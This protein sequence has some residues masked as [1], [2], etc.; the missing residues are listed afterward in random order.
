MAA[1]TSIASQLQAIK[2]FVKADAEPLKKPFIRPSLLFD[3]KEAAD[4]DIDTIYS[5]AVSGLESLVSV[6]AHFEAYKNDLFSHQ[7]KGLD[8]ELMNIEE[9]N[10]INL[11]INSYLRL[12][13]GHLRLPAAF[14]TLEYLIR[15]YKIH[16]Y[17][18]E[19]LILCALPY[20][21]THA[22]VRIV[23][24]IDLGNTKW[25]FLDG[26]K[27]SGAPPPRKIIVQ[28]CV[29]DFGVVESLCS[30]ATPTKKN[31]QSLPVI[32]FCITVV[33]EVL[34]SVATVDNDLVK[35]ILPFVAGI[36]SG[37]KGIS[38]CKAG[39][40]MIVGV[41][42]NRAALSEKL[43]KCLLRSISELAQEAE[44]TDLQWFQMSMMAL[45]SLVQLQS[46]PLL[47][48]KVLD[49]IIT[50]RDLSQIIS[51]LALKFNIE[52]FLKVFVSS[53]I[54]YS[55]SD[56]LYKTALIS[57]LKDAPMKGIMNYTISRL[58]SSC[59]RLAQDTNSSELPQSG[60]W[61]KQVLVVINE[62]YPE[63]FRNAFHRFMEDAKVQSK[64]ES[65]VFDS[66]CRMLDGSSNVEI[67]DSKIWFALEHPKADIRRAMLHSLDTSKVLDDDAVNYQRF[68]SIQ[69]AVLRRL[70]DD[71]LDVIK[72]ALSLDRLSEL[73]GSV[74]LLEVLQDVLKKS[75]DMLL[76]GT[77]KDSNKA[78]DICLSCMELAATNFDRK[79]DYIEELA[80]MVFPFLL[81][82]P[83]TKKLNF[84]VQELVGNI[85]WPLYSKLCFPEKNSGQDSSFINTHI[86]SSLAEVFCES[87][88]EHLPWL[89]K[90]SD[91]N[92]LSKTTLLLILLQSCVSLK[93]DARI[94]NLFAACFNFLRNEWIALEQYGDLLSGDEIKTAT[95]DGSCIKLLDQF[96][97]SS[98][99]QLNAKIMRS[100]F[101][102]LV[103]SYLSALP[104]SISWDD[105]GEWSCKLS[106]LY[107]FF[108]ERK[109]K[110]L[111][112]GHLQHIVQNLKVSPVNFFS[113]FITQGGFSTGAQ[114]TSLNSLT[115]L[116]STTDESLALQLFHEFP[117]VIVPLSSKAQDVRAAA[118]DFVEGLLSLWSRIQS[119]GKRNGNNESWSSS[120]DGLL[121]LLVQ[122]KKLITSDRNFLAS[123]FASVLSSSPQGLLVPVERFDKSTMD[124]ILGFILGF[125]M[126]LPEYAKLKVLLI[127][128]DAGASMMSVK[129][130]QCLLSELLQRL[131]SSHFGSNTLCQ[132]LS[133]TDVDI[134]CLLLETC[135]NSPSPDVHHVQ[136]NLL[137]ALQID[138]VSASDPA[139][140]RTCTTILLNLNDCFISSLISEKQEILL[141]KLVL[142][143]QSRNTIVQNVAKDALLRLT[144]T[145]SSVIRMLESIDLSENN[146]ILT[147]QQAKKKSKKRHTENANNLFGH[148]T[149]L[150]FVS[151]LLDVMLLK[152]DIMNRI[153]LAKPLFQ[154]LGRVFSDV[155][156]Q[157]VDKEQ[158]IQAS[159]GI[160]QS[161]YSTICY[162][163][164]TI[165][166]ILED[167]ARSISCD[168]L[169]K[170]CLICD[171]DIKLLVDCASSCKEVPFLN[172][173]FSLFSTFTKI[174]PRVT[175]PHI[176]DILAV[177]CKSTLSQEDN[178]SKSVFE[179]L[180]SAVV[181]CWLSNGKD[182]CSLLQIFIEVMGDVPQ[183]RRLAVILHILRTLG[184]QQSLGS[185]FSLLIRSVVTRKKLSLPDDKKFLSNTT[186]KEIQTEWEYMFALQICEQ[187][188]T[189][190]W[191]P[192]LVVLLKQ[193][194]SGDGNQQLFTELL[195][196][197]KF[198]Q[199]RLLDP[200]LLFK[201][202]SE[203]GSDTVQGTLGELV[204]QVVCCSVLVD[205]R[206][207]R[208][209]LPAPVKKEL[210][211]LL[212]G[213]LISITKKMIPSTLFRATSILMG[214]AER[215]ITKKALRLLC[216]TVRDSGAV[217]SN[218]GRES[219]MYLNNAWDKL[220]RGAFDTLVTLCSEILQM[221]DQSH[222]DEPDQSL[223]LA[224]VSA[225]EVLASRF[226]P[227]HPISNKCLS[228]MIKNILSDDLS[229]ASSCLK[230]TGAFINILGRRALPELPGIMANI[231]ERPR[232]L[233]LP[234]DTGLTDHKEKIML[235]LLVTLEALVEKLG[236][237][238][239]PY[240]T[241]ILE[242]LVLNPS[243][244]SDS[245]QKLKTKAEAVRQLFSEQIPVRL[246]LPPLLKMYTEAVKSGDLSLQ[247]VF[248]MLTSFVSRMDRES[249]S[250][251]HG[252]IFNLLLLALD[253]RCQHN[254]RIK[255]IHVVE[256]YVS[257][258]MVALTMK[259]TET[260]FKPLFIRCIEWVES[261]MEVN[262]DAVK[263][264]RAIAFYHLV[265]KLVE[266]HRSL[267]VP[268]FKYLLK[269]CI[270]YLSEDGKSGTHSRK[271]KKAKLEKIESTNVDS[272]AIALG[273]WHLCALVLSSLHKCFLYDTGNHKFL[274]S[275]NFQE[276]VKP[277]VAQMVSVPPPSLEE[278]IDVP[279]E[280][281]VDDL[282]V[283][284]I[285][286]MAVA[287]GS[288]LLWKPLNYEV[289]MQTRSEAV[290]TRILGL[291]IVKSFIENLK[292][293]YVVLLAETIPFLV[294]LLEDADLSVKTLAQDT[295][296]ELE[297]MSGENLRDYF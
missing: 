235:S 153:S 100:T 278:E 36:Q 221:V 115:A 261:T 88:E 163:Q 124:D 26:V 59:L 254:P 20:H 80:T 182:T 232:D 150:G 57:I 133:N 39:A 44:S 195:Y 107:V 29:R 222:V 82:F 164:Q 174:F 119:M 62:K 250:S 218:G 279:S 295:L 272:G 158:W 142:L 15:R 110:N 58:L 130:V 217:K 123:L 271:K 87:P 236:S 229:V 138:D 282:L 166:L 54:N 134:L 226:P 210:K 50:F 17:N 277:I 200:E 245:D 234:T 140:L 85:K 183:H 69:D 72:A 52:K 151:S 31:Q 214:H 35:R 241:N 292:E 132:K 197:A 188:S 155:K 145:S 181:P 66:L 208:S 94:S 10:R 161:I 40:L 230:T 280:K 231:L 224:A 186:T 24:L 291:K 175:L 266:N 91:Y 192:S 168:I 47:P 285:G 147:P 287:A 106:E 102:N 97:F 95:L 90:C 246:A 288:D 243:C 148:T 1:S 248:E 275:S 289:L 157:G 11:T 75:T 201:L 109:L 212:H 38:D 256:E 16:V 128:K 297:L 2:S 152:K 114:V 118:M 34:G 179:D 12:I 127:F 255:R 293:E 77:S 56:D 79:E 42:A 268:Y 257:N 225:V 98:H 249:V 216:E 53:L 274:D 252:E 251:Y 185:L 136:D 191:L 196:A 43:V 18:M 70:Y 170:D 172:Q 159:S 264:D 281:E 146:S 111:F 3:P 19:E 33:V 4:T 51:G 22:F 206:R 21:D 74:K 205:T 171:S 92:D 13:S 220:D 64:G 48:K 173:A 71:D 45:I 270:E 55:E 41:M 9:N 259:L 27:V 32:S 237:F 239:N 23:Q 103:T 25:K 211:E 162:I 160:S 273:K 143:H 184:E 219:N 120:V 81:V 125:A 6:D 290:R 61:A 68:S 284:C 193:R 154:L 135:C 96:R 84:K 178:Y 167:I 76:S 269:G 209:I 207:D 65:L 204:E 108:A 30:Y 260:M 101:W 89:V 190:T 283:S 14:K 73:I 238:L 176:P 227:N 8:R 233:L 253:L 247:I 228:S 189:T 129:D 198:V 126:K 267:F 121:R 203:D 7:S 139:I 213:L 116:C 113:M 99:G 215:N 258:A 60:T 244:I 93:N 83:K 286:Q 242:L 122:Q 112:T 165:L 294:E 117:S 187:Y 169:P 131:Q 63:E 296:K 194:Q 202:D 265:N 156:V 240:L 49:S 104:T 78:R 180:I 149:T 177:S 262:D 199:E 276:L 67:S 37:A 105:N 86:I 263:I 137:A 5:I 144:I 28:Q 46:V 141:K 223:K